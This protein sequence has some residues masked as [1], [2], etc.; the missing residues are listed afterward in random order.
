MRAKKQKLFKQNKS[1]LRHGGVDIVKTAA[2]TA[3]QALHRG[4]Q[5][6]KKTQ[7]KKQDSSTIT[8]QMSKT[9]TNNRSQQHTLKTKRDLIGFIVKNKNLE[10]N[11]FLI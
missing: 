11:H 2:A 6:R 1:K 10:K 4:S 3:I 7:K 8:S 9:D 5:Y